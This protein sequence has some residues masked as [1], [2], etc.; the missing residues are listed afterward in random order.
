MKSG[1]VLHPVITAFV[2]LFLF[3]TVL[4]ATTHTT[5]EAVFIQ[6]LADQATKVLSDESI[7]LE[8]R[9]AQ[10]RELLHDGFALE[11]IGRFVVGKHWR[12]MTPEQQNDYLQLY[13]EWVLKTYSSRLGGYSGQAFTVIKTMVTDKDDIFVSSRISHPDFDEPI[14]VDW[15]VRKIGD[16]LKV[17]DVVVEGISM[18]VTQRSEFSAVLGKAGIE[19]LIDTM[20]VRVSKFPAMS[21]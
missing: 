3:T 12:K 15:R 1:R 8:A 2:G 6:S 18:L 10:F 11:K 5:D 4:A 17:I 16:K 19:G 13:G 21:G 20:R 7:S 9:E 14:R